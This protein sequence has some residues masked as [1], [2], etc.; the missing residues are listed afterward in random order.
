MTAG[1]RD[2]VLAQ[3]PRVVSLPGAH[4]DSPGP[5]GPGTES[6]PAGALPLCRDWPSCPRVSLGLPLQAPPA[7]AS[8]IQL[9]KVGGGGD[10]HEHRLGVWGG[11]HR[12]QGSSGAIPNGEGTLGV[13]LTGHGV[14]LTGRKETCL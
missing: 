8:A 13:S 12:P 2:T 10:G 7:L 5:L 11:A 14:V 4:T 3:C 6:R 9:G 1:A